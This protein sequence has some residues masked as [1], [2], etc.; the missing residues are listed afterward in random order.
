MQMIGDAKAGK[1]DMIIT[2]EVSRFARNTVDTLKYTRELK[3]HKVEVFFINDNI[4]TF[5]GDG[6][7][8]LTL[9]ATLAQDES[10]KTSVRV[11][12][13]QQTSMNNGV[14]YGNGN[15]LGYDRVGKELV[16]NPEQARTVRLIYDLYLDGNGLVRIKDEY[17]ENT[18]KVY[19][20]Y[21]LDFIENHTEVGKYVTKSDVN[22]F[23]KRVSKQSTSTKTINTKI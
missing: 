12:S 5:D 22:D 16:L 10:R 17:A 23:K 14:L 3:D 1:F 18:V 7:L 20:R 11:K 15:I 6:E 4:K 21:A 8:R 19:E 13:G 2:R 9:M